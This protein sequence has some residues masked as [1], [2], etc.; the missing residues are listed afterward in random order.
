[1]RFPVP[2]YISVQIRRIDGRRLWILKLLVTLVVLVT[3]GVVK[4]LNILLVVV[5]R[6]LLVVRVDDGPLILLVVNLLLLLVRHLVCLLFL[7][8]LVMQSIHLEG[9]VWVNVFREF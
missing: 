2:L 9:R 8:P 7:L 3:V 4:V 6:Y 1:M 5:L